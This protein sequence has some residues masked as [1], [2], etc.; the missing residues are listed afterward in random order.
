MQ[1]TVLT[2]RDAHIDYPGTAEVLL[3]ASTDGIRIEVR[4]PDTE[5]PDSALYSSAVWLEL[6]EGRLMVHVYTPHAGD[7][8]A[9]E[10]ESYLLARVTQEGAAHERSYTP[11]YR[12]SVE[13]D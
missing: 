10:P 1:R 13:S 6:F 5:A 11:H 4:S 8:T 3:E 9:E 12:A 2:L 7:G